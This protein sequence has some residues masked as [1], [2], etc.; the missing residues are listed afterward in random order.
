M[1]KV[2][3]GCSEKVLVVRGHVVRRPNAALCCSPT[4]CLATCKP[5]RTEAQ[6]RILGCAAHTAQTLS[7]FPRLETSN[8][9]LVPGENHCAEKRE[10]HFIFQY[11]A[12]IRMVAPSWR[13]CKHASLAL[14]VGKPRVSWWAIPIKS[15]Q[16]AK[17]GSGGVILDTRR[18][19]GG[20]SESPW[21]WA[22]PGSLPF[23][24]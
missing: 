9:I 11:P 13:W 4:K 21:V 19:K 16:E 1:T 10:K 18:N 8:K 6:L 14:L 2:R 15:P 3:Q 17:V 23:L 22:Q 20:N 24:Q 12:V 7:G 5:L